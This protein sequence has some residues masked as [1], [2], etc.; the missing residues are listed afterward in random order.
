MAWRSPHHHMTAGA[1]VLGQGLVLVLV[2]WWWWW[3][4][5]W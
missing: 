2:W 5:W 4:W 1:L 3:W